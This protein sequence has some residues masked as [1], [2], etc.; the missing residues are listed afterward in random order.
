METVR[1]EKN[2]QIR[3]KTGIDNLECLI[4]LKSYL[5][6]YEH[7]GKPIEIEVNE[8]MIPVYKTEVYS[9]NAHGNIAGGKYWFGIDVTDEIAEIA[10]KGKEGIQTLIVAVKNSI[11]LPAAIKLVQEGA[12]ASDI[13]QNFNK[14]KPSYPI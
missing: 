7:L 10:K 12:T 3:E 8:K 13:I 14:S 11:N 5:E 2:L 6:L 9:I 4:L 1:A